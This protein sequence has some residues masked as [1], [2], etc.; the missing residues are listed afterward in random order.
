MILFHTIL[1]EHPAALGDRLLHALGENKA[2][3]MPCV[4]GAQL[5]PGAESALGLGCVKTENVKL[6]LEAHSLYRQ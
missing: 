3:L 4:G 5:A 1:D 6:R 2:P